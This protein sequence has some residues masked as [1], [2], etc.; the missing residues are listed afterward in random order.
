[1]CFGVGADIPAMLVGQ[2]LK[3]P[4]RL[5][6]TSL[7]EVTLQSAVHQENTRKS[8]RKLEVAFETGE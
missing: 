4:V 5:H 3:N 6:S 2:G 1:V 8:S 7:S